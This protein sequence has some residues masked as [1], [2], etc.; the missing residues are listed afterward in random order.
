MLTFLDLINEVKRRATLDQGGTQFDSSIKNALNSSL[1]R[2]AREASWRVLRRT[3]SLT[4]KKPYSQGSGSGTYTSGSN[5]IVITGANFY[6]EAINIGRRIK[7]SGSSQYY[8]IEQITSDTSCNIERTY[9]NTTVSGS[10]TYEI[11]GQEEYNLPVQA[12]HSM[13]LWHNEYGYPYKMEYVTT[14]DFKDRGIIDTTEGIPTCYYMWGE[15]MA[16]RQ[17]VTESNLSI[18]SSDVADTSIDVT[19]FGTVSGYP[20]YEKITT[21]A[22][23]GTTAVAGSK[24]FSKVERVTKFSNS[25]GRI[26]V[27]A[28]NVSL[29][30]MLPVGD[31]TA[32]VLYKKIRV[33]PLPESTFPINVWYYKNPYR[34]VNDEDIHELGQE[35]DE[36]II[37][38]ATA[39]IKYQ[40]N[41]AEGDKFLA[42]YTDEVR[43]LRKTN[44][45]KLDFFPTLRSPNQSKSDLFGPGVSYRQVGGEYGRQS[46]Y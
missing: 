21:S 32:G 13:F 8:T 27:T 22:V 10:G 39:K 11:L 36:A 43:N 23:S 16:I 42:L 12:S 33:H 31:T 46:R 25:T 41:Q 45:D 14:Q 40:Q 38:L 5:H 2:L 17:L 15:D 19:I 29:V 6:T 34:L 28:N 4:T 44:I 24:V 1:L 3:G 20:D 35:F 26:S 30:A 9:D 37:L 18:V 7:L